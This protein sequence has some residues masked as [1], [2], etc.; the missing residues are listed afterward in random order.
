MQYSNLP[1]KHYRFRVIASNNSGVWN[2]EGATLDFVIPP[3]WYQTNLFLALC[4]AV[5]VGLLWAAYQLRL[6]QMQ[7]QFAAGL[8]ERV[9]ERLRIARELHDTLLQSFQGALFQFQAARKLLERKA[10]NA[11]Q[12]LDEAILAA[13]EGIVEGRDAIR[14]LR[15]E[16]VAQRNLVELLNAMGHELAGTQELN[17]HSPRFEVFV[18][19]KQQD[20]SPMLQDEVI[21]SPAR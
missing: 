8:E 3:A 11:M 4:V 12:V 5:F 6:H 1:P 13:E 21:G 14:D 17:G 20:L 9:G 7:Q 15:P 10:D 18:E 2:E 19:G 16:P